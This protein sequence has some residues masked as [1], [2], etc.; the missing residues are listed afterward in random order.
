MLYRVLEDGRMMSSA[1]AEEDTSMASAQTVDGSA[2]FREARTD[3]RI[4]ERIREREGLYQIAD[5]R[6]LVPSIYVHTYLDY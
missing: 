3:Q 2:R 6:S 5:R 4:R 1:R